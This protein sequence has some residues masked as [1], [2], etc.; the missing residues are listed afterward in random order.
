[1]SLP[2]PTYLLILPAGIP[3]DP[4]PTDDLATPT[5]TVGIDL[6]N[7]SFLSVLRSKEFPSLPAI[8]HPY[9]FRF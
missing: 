6:Q 7:F 4:L 3:A 1:M 8:D 2:T 5:G 9:S